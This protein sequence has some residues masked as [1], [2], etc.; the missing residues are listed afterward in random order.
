MPDSRDLKEQLLSEVS[1]LMSRQIQAVAADASLRR[2]AAS[3]EKFLLRW[4]AACP[5]RW[6]IQWNPDHN[7]VLA[8]RFGERT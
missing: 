2:L 1:E 3:W 6:P 7:G 4:L 5:R 8:K